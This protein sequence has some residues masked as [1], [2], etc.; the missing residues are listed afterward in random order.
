[1]NPLLFPTDFS[2]SADQAFRYAL[3]MADH[4]KTSIVVL[5]VYQL[6]DIRGTHLPASL[7][8]V[9]KTFDLEEFQNFR[10]AIPHMRD[11]AAEMGMGHIELKHM[12]EEGETGT[13]IIRV[14]R[15]LN[16]ALLVLS[17]TGITGIREII[18]GSVTAE[19]LENSPCPV[20]A[21]PQEARMDGV[22]DQI[23]IVSECQPEEVA[24]LDKVLEIASWFGAQVFCLQVDG[25]SSNQEA[26]RG[27][28]DGKN[29][30]SF[31]SLGLKADMEEDL[32][33]YLEENPVDIL[34]M[35]TRRRSFFQNLFHKGQT[36]K[37]AF[38]SNVPVLSVQAV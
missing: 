5:H 31:Q 28:F 8:E 10:D 22:V 17:T 26:F 27:R 3:Q 33:K 20:F 35:L 19:I 32:L 11:L 36:R 7:Q 38:S 2:P 24:V 21:V 25:P 1:M 12:L 30:L 9:Y 23:A 18:F 14:A 29:N 34:A 13:T 6:P 4:L 15:E 16:P 37:L